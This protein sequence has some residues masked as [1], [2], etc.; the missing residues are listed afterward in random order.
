MQLFDDMYEKMPWLNQCAFHMDLTDIGETHDIQK[1]QNMKA[2]YN[3][4]EEEPVTNKGT[5]TKEQ[6]EPKTD[7][8]KNH[9]TKKETSSI[10]DRETDKKGSN[11][12]TSLSDRIK[13]AKQRADQRNKIRSGK[14]NTR[15]NNHNREI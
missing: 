1:M 14:A 12:N 7:T 6:T 15:S 8:R 13:N 5:K 4:I 2:A 10:A 11:V 9:E 3:R